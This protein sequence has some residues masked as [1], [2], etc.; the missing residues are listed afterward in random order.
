MDSLVDG[1]LAD[2]TI[3]A[4]RHSL[5]V[6]SGAKALAR[7]GKHDTSDVRFESRR[8]E[9]ARERLSHSARHGVASL[10]AVQ[11]KRKHA[12]IERG[13]EIRRTS[14]QGGDS[15]QC[16][17]IHVAQTKIFQFSVNSHVLVLRRLGTFVMTQRSPSYRAPI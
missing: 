15:H 13:E 2:R 14:V 7:A 4:R 11:G 9:L 5:D 10:R 8:R 3:A 6:A 1:R 12:L 17:P 16:F